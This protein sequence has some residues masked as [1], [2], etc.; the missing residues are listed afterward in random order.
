MIKDRDKA[1]IPKFNGRALSGEK[2][3][4]GHKK[5][6]HSIGRIP[7]LN[8]KENFEHTAGCLSIRGHISIELI[9]NIAN[10]AKGLMMKT[11]K[12]KKV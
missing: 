4:D 6:R 9:E 12:N 3:W 2:T 11:E 7:Q 1:G 8:R 10:Q 5:S